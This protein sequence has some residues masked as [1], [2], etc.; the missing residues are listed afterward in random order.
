MGCNEDTG[1]KIQTNCRLNISVMMITKYQIR[2]ASHPLDAKTYDTDRIRKEFLIPVL[3]EEDT[4]NWYYSEY[5]R[6]MVGGIFPVSKS[7]TLETIEPLKS[8]FFLERREIGMINIG[9]DARISV[10]GEVIEL[11]NKEALYIGKGFQKVVFASK[12][13]KVPAKIYINSA[14]AHASYPFK[15]VNLAEADS[16]EMGTIESSNQRKINRLIINS[17]VKTCQ[18]QMGLTEF[19]PGSVWNTMPP[20]THS[21]RMEAYFYFD[22]AEN[23]AVCH[24][25]GDPSETRHIWLQ[26]EQA[27]ISPPWSIHAG[28]G[29]AKYSFI[30]GMAGE[31]L[32]YSDMDAVKPSDL[33]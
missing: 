22:L 29:T 21:R 20:H 2:S 16:L 33:R 9:G 23:Q 17:I 8:S 15:K 10:D 7:L 30:W 26:N 18:L 4:I 11:A 32:D 14:P 1:A 27:V 12:D 24:F 28:V 19:L 25:M 3:F 6:Y 5:D 13:K 31:N